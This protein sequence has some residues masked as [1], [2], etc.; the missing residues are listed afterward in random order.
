MLERFYRPLPPCLFNFSIH[1]GWSGLLTGC[2]IVLSGRIDKWE[3][4]QLA[5]RKLPTLESK[6]GCPIRIW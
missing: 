5:K 1:Q 3:V 4:L 2:L 6:V